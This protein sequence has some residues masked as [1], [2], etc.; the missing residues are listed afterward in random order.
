[1]NKMINVNTRM[2]WL[3]VVRLIAILMVIVSHSVDSLNIT[4]VALSSPSV[5]WGSIIGSVARACVPLFAMMTGLLLMPIG[6]MNIGAFYKK[7]ILRVLW[8]FLIWS[9]LYNLFPWIAG[10]LGADI[11]L[12]GHFFPA[13]GNGGS[14]AFIDALHNIITIPLG[15]SLY[16]T[17]MWYIYML[18]GLYLFLP[19][20]F[21]WIDQADRLTVRLYLMS[22]CLE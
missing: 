15:F 7:R 2:V 4:S 14:F 16:N 19:F 17:H 20:L 10:L 9:T 21:S 5:N 11:E 22:M 8:P 3:D 1:M 12:L 18:I 6:T 13:V